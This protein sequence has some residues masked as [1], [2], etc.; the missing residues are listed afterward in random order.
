MF[1]TLQQNNVCAERNEIA[2]SLLYVFTRNM[3][4]EMVWWYFWYRVLLLRAPGTKTYELAA[5][6]RL[7]SQHD[8]HKSHEIPSIPMGSQSPPS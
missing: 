6:L 1:Y 7:L 5:H 4:R 2:R 8:A 3:L